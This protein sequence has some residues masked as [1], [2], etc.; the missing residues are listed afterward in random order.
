M[1]HESIL[2]RHQSVLHHQITARRHAPASGPKGS[3]EHPPVLDLGQVDDSVGL[4]L[5]I[6]RLNG[7]EQDGVD[8]RGECRRAQAVE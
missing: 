7:S 5:D 6:V 8:L 2:P 3:V 1:Y 4:D